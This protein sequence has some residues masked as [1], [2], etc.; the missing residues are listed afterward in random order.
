MRKSFG[1]KKREKKEPMELDITS[2]LDILVILLVFLLKNYN[3]S[4]LTIDLVKGVSL[5]RSESQILGSHAVIV[6]VN[7]SQEIF[8]DNTKI[9]NVGGSEKISS[10]YE[11]LTNLKKEEKEK[12]SNRDPAE[13]V[14]S[15]NKFKYNI[16]LVLHKDLPYKVLRKIMNT[17]AE[18]GYPQFKFIVQGKNN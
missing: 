16:N 11:K 17:S 1:K 18:A 6:Q 12:S 15:K 10:L 14:S 7:K 13:T 5:A 3:A 4:D 8:I 9:G 2:L